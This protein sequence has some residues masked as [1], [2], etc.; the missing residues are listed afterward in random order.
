[1][2]EGS[3]FYWPANEAP[4]LIGPSGKRHQ[5]EVDNLVPYLPDPPWYRMIMKMPTLWLLPS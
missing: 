3:S 2:E 5:L 4:Y 1:M